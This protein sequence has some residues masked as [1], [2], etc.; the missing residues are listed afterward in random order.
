MSES[1]LAAYGLQPKQVTLERIGTGLINHTWK[2]STGEEVFILQKINEHVFTSPADIAH[3]TCVVAA[4]LKKHHPDYL[5]VAPVDGQ[6]GNSLIYREGEG[7]FRLFPFVSGSHSKDTVETADQAYEAAKQFG[8]FTR[9]STGM[10]LDQ[11]RTT[12]PFFHD[13]EYRYRKFLAALNA[14][15]E[16]RL[17]ESAGLSQKLIAHSNLADIYKM[18]K[19]NPSFRLRVTHHDTK[20]SNVLFD[21]RGKGLCIIDLDTLM[22]GHFISDLGD[23]MRTYLSPA[24]EE[25]SDTDAIIVREDFYH[26]IVEG[27]YEEMKD[28]LSAAEKDHFF[29]SAL[30]MTYMQALRFLTDHL[31]NDLYYSPVYPGQNLVRARNQVMLLERLLEKKEVLV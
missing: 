5:F 18:I 19:A 29:Y 15:D 21:E 14:A 1:V 16:I 25:Q 4:Y 6:Q 2:V 27:Y 11:L 30:F 24:N 31:Q 10:D 13:L 20:I 9:L 7:Y 23:M 22:P 17:K 12:I 3:N 8:R 26:A 28:E